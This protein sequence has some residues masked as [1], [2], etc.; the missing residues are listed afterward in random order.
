MTYDLWSVYG[1]LCSCSF[2]ILSNMPEACCKRR[3]ATKQEL[4]EHIKTLRGDYEKNIPL[5][6][7]GYVPHPAKPCVKFDTTPPKWAEVKLMI[8][9]ERSALRSY[10]DD[11]TAFLLLQRRGPKPRIS[12]LWILAHR[13]RKER[14][15]RILEI[16]P[17]DEQYKSKVI[18]QWQ[19][20]G[21]MTWIGIIRRT[22]MQE[23]DSPS[24]AEL[25]HGSQIMI[26]LLS[27]LA[28]AIPANRGDATAPL[29]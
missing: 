13:S 7:P 27:T 21:W 2:G 4:Q 14:W 1:S 8:G 12:R 5:A 26:L 25:P 15:A 17:Q 10:M 18:S 11:V 28:Y 9:K 20:G 19:Q 29:F 16:R 24:Q 6:L 3:K 22:G 23:E